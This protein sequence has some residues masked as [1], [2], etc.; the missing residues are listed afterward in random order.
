ME[1]ILKRW[2]YIGIRGDSGDPIEIT[3]ET[4]KKLWDAISEAETGICL[5]NNW[6]YI[7]KRN[8]LIYKRGE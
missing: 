8:A 3:A 5:K 7:L 6:K 1:D 2:G 4:V